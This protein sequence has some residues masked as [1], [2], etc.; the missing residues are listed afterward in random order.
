MGLGVQPQ[1]EHFAIYTFICVWEQY[2]QLL[3]WHKIVTHILVFTVLLKTANLIINWLLS[4]ATCH[5]NERPPL[6][7]DQIWRQGDNI[8]KLFNELGKIWKCNL[9]FSKIPIS[10]LFMNW[11]K[12][13][14]IHSPRP[15]FQNT[16]VEFMD[17]LEYLI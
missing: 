14:K 2:F 3:N 13:G 12:L 10:H 16:N 4:D 1:Q 5:R 6:P 17:G 11:E 9:N 15:T 7:F 8:S